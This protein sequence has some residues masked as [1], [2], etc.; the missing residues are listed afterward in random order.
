MQ[1]FLLFVLIG[2]GLGAMYTIAAQGL[3][4][5]YRGS[6]VLNFA[7]GAVGM[8]GAYFFFE[9]TVNHGM[10]FVPGLILGILLSALVGALIH[11]LIMRQLRRASPL[12]RVVAT[13]G[14]LITLESIAVLH[15][16]GRVTFLPSSLPHGT[17]RLF[18]SVFIGDDRLVLLGIALVLTIGLWLAYRY[19]RFGLATSAVA[20]SERAAASLG[21]SPDVI[22]TANWALGSALAG[23]AAILISPIVTLQVASMTN[24]VLAALA[25]A[26]IASFRSFPIAFIGGLVVG[27]A[28][29]LL[30][31]YAA[32]VPG[33]SDSLPFLLIVLV[34]MVRGQSLPLRDYLLQELPA[35]GTG[36]IRPL[37]V[38][39]SAGL[40]VLLIAIL[41]LSWVIGLTLTFGPGLVLL[42]V[43]VVTGYA[44]Q[45]SLAQ[46]AFAGFGAWIAGRL[47]AGAHFPFWAAGLISV[48]ATIPVGVAFALPA[49]RTRGITLAVV[50]LGLGTAVEYMIFDNGPLTGGLNGT[51]VANSK[52]FGLN[53]DPVTHPGRFAYLAL[54]LFLVAALAVA[55]LRR[56]RSGRRM[57]AVR[58]N[59]RAAAALGVNVAA[60]KLYAFGLSAAIAALGGI[61]IA[62]QADQISY[63]ST[64]TNF[65]SVSDVGWGVIGGLGYVIG[66]L[67]GATLSPGS[68]GTVFLN[69]ILGS[70]GKYLPLIGGVTLILLV[71]QNQNGVVHEVITQGRWIGRK[72]GF[73]RRAGDRAGEDLA[74][75][76]TAVAGSST[77]GSQP[78]REASRDEISKVAPKVVDVSG[79][80]VRYGAT[81]AVEDLSFQIQPGNVLGLIGPNGAGKTTVIDAV[82]GFTRAAAG[83]I[84]LD[85]QSV[86]AWGPSKRA[87]TGFSRSFQSLELFEDSTVRD[88]LR[89]AE[90]PRDLLS[91]LRD[92]I[93]P[94]NTPLSDDALAAVREFQLQ[95]DLDK[96]AE[97]LSYGKRRLLAIARAVA[98]RPNV[99][100]LDEPAAGLGDAETAE[101]ARLVRRLAEEWGMGIL[102]IEHD[103]NFVMSVCDRLV[104]VDFGR[105]IAEGTPVEVRTNPA[106]IAAYLG[107]TEDEVKADAVAH[108]AVGAEEEGV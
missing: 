32:G 52:L 31:R 72:L 54:A 57:I 105:K 1:E 44:G 9:L 22:A 59:E 45:L 29:T 98:A 86:A 65:T 40:G 27:I 38:V 92:P 5:I 50:T 70:A 41:P 61:V 94:V 88:N 85:G 87:R 37:W 34:L 77:G 107:E 55:N 24:L 101:L 6:G 15:Y 104:V 3:I 64:F 81:T 93:T 4:L 89:T 42:S 68:I 83:E 91:Y 39:A 18:G 71:L 82:T 11:L 66:P 100:L 43:V 62:F 12:T 30:Q 33:L 58:T 14:A 28:Q 48:L 73:G 21:W 20:E 56:S 16:G 79:L 47:V 7:H 53:I 51:P 74:A 95:H 108:S 13:L 97:D 103:M 84:T 69:S 35:L 17:V 10:A 102:L 8:V 80:T 106:V 75:A 96:R 25:V 99:L 63:S 90:D 46:F 19:T 78:T 76:D 49:V 23:L 60:T 2:L 26:L 67:S 36:R